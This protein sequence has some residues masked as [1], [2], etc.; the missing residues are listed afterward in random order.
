MN[1]AK[2]EKVYLT[3]TCVS[4]W[5]FANV[6]VWLFEYGETYLIQGGRIW[7]MFLL[8][9]SFIWYT[10]T[11]EWIIHINFHKSYFT[12][13]KKKKKK[14]LSSPLLSLPLS[15]PPAIFL[16]LYHFHLIQGRTVFVRA[17]AITW[18]LLP[19]ILHPEARVNIKT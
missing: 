6:S 9:C 17:T 13:K 3:L 1:K 15:I 2:W 10:H 18:Y 8:P 11:Q 5:V 19:S 16:H 14:S 4:L 7:V 12:Y